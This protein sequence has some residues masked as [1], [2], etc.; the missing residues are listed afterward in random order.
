MTITDSKITGRLL[1]PDTSVPLT[2]L[3]SQQ[4]FKAYYPPS[5]KLVSSS[6]SRIF[7]FIGLAFSL[8]FGLFCTII[9]IYIAASK[10]NAY[11]VVLPPSWPGGY[12][13]YNVVPEM[14]AILPNSAQ[15]PIPA[16]LVRFALTQLNTI[17]TEAIGFIHAVT[18]RST[19]ATH[20]VK[21]TKREENA[22]RFN[23]NLRLFTAP[24]SSDIGFFHPNAAF[25]NALMALLLILS[26]ASVSL[27]MLSFTAA[28]CADDEENGQNRCDNLPE[29]QTAQAKRANSL[30]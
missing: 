3:S 21:A 1:K 30:D 19:L 8:S 24:P 16:V 23:T 28:V 13:I 12:P 10:V 11:S 6:S 9:G 7:A 17:C 25:C 26:Y 27:A 29:D 18:Q 20:S 22:L 14:V 5:V 2:S 4:D 15:H